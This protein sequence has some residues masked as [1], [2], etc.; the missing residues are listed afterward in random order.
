MC[1]KT[2]KSSEA[3]AAAYAEADRFADS[4]KTAQ[5]T[6][7]LA[8]AEGSLARANSIRTQVEA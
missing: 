4:V 3:L 7:Q 5:R 1:L 6:L 8:T 2:L